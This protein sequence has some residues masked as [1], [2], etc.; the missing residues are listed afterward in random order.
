[1][2][3]K[4]CLGRGKQMRMASFC[5]IMSLL[6]LLLFV[7]CSQPRHYGKVDSLNNLSYAFHY[8]NLDSTRFYAQKAY[9][10]ASEYKDGQAEALNNL[11]F[12]DMAKMDYPKAQEHLNEIYKIT[13]NQLELLVADVQMM[14]LCQRQSKNKEF[15][16]Y[17]QR[18]N[19]RLNRIGEEEDVLTPRQRQ[20][21]IYGKSEYG[22]VSSTYFYYVGLEKQSISAFHRIDP[23]GSIV[24]DTAQMLNYYYN[25]GAGGLILNKD[26][27]A[28]YR[29]E[30]ENLIHCYL[31]AHQCD[32]PYWVANSLQAMSEHLQSSEGREL[33][34]DF[35]AEIQYVNTDKMPDSLLAGNLAQRALQIFQTYGDV[36]QTAG[37]YRTLGE[38][39][40]AIGDYRS[41]II[42][43]ETALAHNKA[44]NQAP[45]LVA[46]IREQLCM[47][48]SA[49]DNKVES[50]ANRNIFLDM[51]EITRQDRELEAR[52]EQ[53]DWQSNMLNIMIGAVIAMILLVVALLF[54]FAYLGKQ[55]DR[56]FS[57]STLLQPLA[58]WEKINEKEEQQVQGELEEFEEQMQI[59]NLQLINNKRKNVEQRAK[60]SLA[61]SIIPFIS[62]IMHEVSRLSEEKN[63]SAACKEH[64]AYAQELTR[65]ISEYNAALTQWIQMRQGEISLHIESFALQE[66]FNVLGHSLT[67]YKIKGIDFTIKPTND[68]VKADKILT[69]FMLNTMAENAR[70]FT[71]EGGQITVES[72]A[73]DDYIE[74]SVSDTG[75]GI[76]ENLQ[77]TLFSHK[78]QSVQ[79]ANA[80]IDANS[81]RPHGFGLVNCKGIIEKYRKMSSVFSVCSIGVESQIGKGSRFYFR[82]P[83]GIVKILIVLMTLFF[84]TN[85][86]KAEKLSL[87]LNKASAFA[88]SAYFSNI[89]GT[90]QR[91]VSFAD[92]CIKYLNLSVSLVHPRNKSQMTLQGEN[93]NEAAE[94]QW[95]HEQ[96]RSNYVTILDIRNET[97]VA[98]LALH[99]WK[100]YTYN[101]KVYSQ[102]FREYSADN[103]LNDYVKVMQKSESNKNVAVIILVFLLLTLF[104]AYYL[105]YYRHRVHYKL[106]RERIDAIN[107]VL[108]GSSSAEHK[109]SRI[110]DIWAKQESSQETDNKEIKALTTIV[111]QIEEALCLKIARNCDIK[112][113]LILAHDE[114]NRII[115]EKEKYY[116]SNNV[117]D[118]CL[119]T[120]KH[121]T[122]YY[123]SRIVQLLSEIQVD[124]SSVQELV[125]YYNDLYTI[126]CEQAMRQINTSGYLDTDMVDYLFELLIKL[127][128]GSKP[129]IQVYDVDGHY[130]RV[131]LCMDALCLDRQQQ[132]NLFT[133]ATYDFR[134]LVCKQ[135]IREWGDQTNARGCGMRAICNSDNQTNIEITLTQKIWKISKLSS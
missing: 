91:T 120:L 116:V 125:G 73:A 63:T 51:Q 57:I 61:F 107:Q 82:L 58:K 21:L 118:N 72:R 130:V 15:Y 83:K 123:P 77:N 50:D 104:P 10:E 81:D 26:K 3:Q 129:K 112:T 46:S 19:L 36:Y 44:V 34:S 24:K 80:G 25:I 131:I 69:L 5:G 85:N 7:G 37:A 75:R 88:D 86:L 124:V 38:C 13:D 76:P 105:L 100:L 84:P 42:C 43:L 67:E 27:S 97:A 96:V 8:R 31:V 114:L 108:L 28:I 54:L 102:L 103:T 30:F 68:V 64:L 109:L 29:E 134:F 23:S 126:L 52:A 56:K 119:S 59:C 92:S 99:D 98:A 47:A 4:M 9:E 78:F 17:R 48:Y 12:V 101:N 122:M 33:L 87:V 20:R 6:A 90:Y 110:Q 71:P 127:N 95:F 39:Y 41:S 115:R 74:I 22:I 18:A 2:E 79:T 49:I 65:K 113:D 132:M 135:I 35:K 40:W 94:L 66:L 32:Y 111:K 133:P 121:E 1:M 14:R 55:S 106:C 45:D 62:R 60:V 16:T 70:K 117:L 128:G 53:L 89:N 11:A 93:P